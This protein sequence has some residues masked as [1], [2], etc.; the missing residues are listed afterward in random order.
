MVGDHNVKGPIIK[1]QHL[2]VGDTG[3][4]AGEIG[5]CHGTGAGDF[6]H[7]GG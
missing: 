3:L 1:G 2:C 5:H 7:A 6:D 4:D